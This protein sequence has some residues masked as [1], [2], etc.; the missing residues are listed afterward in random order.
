MSKSLALWAFESLYQKLNP[1]AAP[2]T[3]K[4]LNSYFGTSAKD[5]PSDAPL[6][7]TWN[8][9]HQLRGCIGTFLGMPTEKGV[10][11]YALVSAFQDSRFPQVSASELP[12]LSVSVTLL[13]NFEPI[14]DPTDW[15]I[16]VHG[17]KVKILSNGRHYLG[18]FLPVVAEEQEWDKKETLW[19]LLRKAGYSG[20]SQLQTIGFYN[21]GISEG[22]IQLTRYEGLKAGLDY[23]EYLEARKKLEG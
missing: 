18:T 5:Y 17:L 10:S 22:W 6:F 19:N 12:S 11:E 15:E 16:G 21:K 7:I 4:D 2:I 9:N 8:K 13:S 20:T 23:A 1:H 3:L 14:E